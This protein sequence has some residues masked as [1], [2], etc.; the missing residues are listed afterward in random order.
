[1]NR[2][3]KTRDGRNVRILATDIKDRRYPVT[4]AVEISG[5][6]YI[7]LYTADGHYA[8]NEESEDDLIEVK[9]RIQR[10]YWM[11]VYEHHISEAFTTKGSAD[12]YAHED[13]LACVEVNI[14]CEVGQGL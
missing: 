1:M 3:Y 2:K 4:A 14:D 9:P 6:E 13:R 11:N 5:V 7:K 10:T 12:R 8:Y